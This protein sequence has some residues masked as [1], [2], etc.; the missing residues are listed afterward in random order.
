[1]II[2]YVNFSCLIRVSVVAQWSEEEI[3]SRE[4]RKVSNA[5][6][7]VRFSVEFLFYFFSISVGYNLTEQK[8]EANKSSSF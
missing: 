5:L 1:M 8:F 3:E 2:K 7:Q 6:P 4:K